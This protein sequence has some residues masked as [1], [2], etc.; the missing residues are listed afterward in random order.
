MLYSDH[1]ALRF[2]K[3]QKKLNSRHASWVSYLEKFS[4]V[5][6]HKAGSSN[7]VANALSRRHSLLTTLSYEIIGFDLLPESYGM[8]PFFSKMLNDG[9]SKDYLMMNGYLFKRNQLC[10]PEGSLRLFVIEKLHAGGLGGHF[11]QDKTEAL[12]KQRYF[13]PSLKHDVARFV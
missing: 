11:R 1:E 2:L 13:W 8:D 7:N 9:K 6:Q 12:V 4:F 10:L 3:S 5:L